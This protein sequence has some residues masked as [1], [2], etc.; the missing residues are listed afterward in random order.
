MAKHPTGPRR[1]AKQKLK[2]KYARVRE[3]AQLGGVI[4]TTPEGAV[5]P[6]AVDPASQGE[7]SLPSLDRGAVRNGWEVPEGVKHKVIERL[8]EP[9]FEEGRKVVAKDG[10]VL[11]LPPDRQL[12]KENAKVLVLADQRQYERDH[13]EAAGKAKGGGGTTEVNV[14]LVMT[15][16]DELLRKVEERRREDSGFDRDLQRVLEQE[17]LPDG[18]GE[19]GGDGGGGQHDGPA[20]PEE[21]VVAGGEVLPEAARG[22][23]RDPDQ[24]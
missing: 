3:D 16:L 12:L 7:Q 10:T 20:T 23:R 6:E 4:A 21:G 22:D 2:E 17:C 13:P 19:R 9:F 14:N 1:K 5:R 8:A 15:N 24:P 18:G 11:T